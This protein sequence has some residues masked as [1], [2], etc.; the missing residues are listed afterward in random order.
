MKTIFKKQIEDIFS[1]KKDAI[2]KPL[3]I[4]KIIADYREKNC[5]VSAHLVKLGIEVE[6][7]ELKV[8]D[9]IIKNIAIERKTVSDFISSMINRRLLRQLEELQQYPQRLLIVEGL[10]EKELYNDD[11]PSVNANAI[12]G[13]LLSIV[14][15]HKVPIIY[16]KNAR[17]TAKFLAVL[18]RK[19]ETETPINAQ[20][21]SLN[22]KE[23]LQFIIEAFPGIGPKTAKKLLEE[24]KTLKNLVNS[25][26]ESLKKILGKKA[27]IMKDLF[28]KEF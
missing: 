4:E 5:L 23:Q 15:K 18:A 17:D 13:F 1:R 12:R 20:K 25:D 14:L 24:F 8:A 2:K 22:A 3:P 9:Y 6:F 10:E 19:K 21:K 26:E 11:N 27:E 28:N 7:K 16:T